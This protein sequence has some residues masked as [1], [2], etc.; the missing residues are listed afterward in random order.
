MAAGKGKRLKSRL[1]KVLHPLC[2]RPVLW[3]VLH[4]VRGAR[5]D[6]IVVVVNHGRGEVEEALAS[7]K[8]RFPVVFVDQGQP[9]GTGH[10]V[11]VAEDAVAGA[12]DVLV[13]NGDE[14]LITGGA[15][16]RLVGTHRRRRAAATLQ[17]TSVDDPGRFGHVVREGDEFVRIVEGA[18]ATPAERAIEEVSMGI[19]VFRREDLFRALP[20]VARDNRQREYYLH[21]VLSVLRDKGERVVVHTVDNGRTVGVNNRADLA[22]AAAVMRRRINEGHMAKGVTFIDPDTTYIDVDVRIARDAILLPQTYLEGRT[23]IGEGARVGPGTRVV[24]ST[25]GRD[26]EVQFSVVRESRVGPRVSVGPYASIRPG[27]VLEEGAKAGTFVE[28]KKSRIGRGTKVPHLSYVGDASIGD[29][30]NIGAGTVTV[31][32]DGYDKHRTT[33]G[34]GARVGS[35]TM[36]VAPVRVGKRAWTG[37]GSTI[38]RDVPEGALGVERADQKVVR[39]YDERRAKARKRRKG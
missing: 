10:A 36:L 39:G 16:R 19:Y 17:S 12:D 24:D 22:R 27:T 5:P 11:M 25:V 18:D 23:R 33:I 38:T 35:D 2:G 8:L 20:L 26:A 9:L 3:H 6:S 30:A 13:V 14:P 32:Y 7:W 31:N 37:A 34:Q 4:A 28:I 21:D 15:L 29:E 1:P